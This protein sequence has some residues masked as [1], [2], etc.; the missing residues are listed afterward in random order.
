MKLSEGVEWG[1]HCV[2]VLAGLPP[3]ATLPTK[4]LAEYHGLSETYLAKHL[5][6]LTNA[7]IIES[8][9]G[10][11]GGYR[12][13][14]APEEI[15]MLEVVEAIDGREPL[16]RCAEIRQRSPL[17]QESAQYRVPCGIHI[18][19]ARAEKAWRDAL[20][21]QTIADIVSHYQQSTGEQRLQESAEWI[22]G[23]MR[24]I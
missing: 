15:T 14:R 5:Q 6:A 19:M 13:R 8:L 1:L 10:P 11:K 20:R 17:T 9:P 12:L 7:G 21:T 23:R 16:F 2:T 4:A 18:A 3:R 24:Q 22:A